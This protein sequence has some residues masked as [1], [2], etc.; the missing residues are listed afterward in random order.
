[1]K[2]INRDA[3]LMAV[4]LICEHPKIGSQ[5]LARTNES[6]FASPATSEVIRRI[7]SHVS[8]KGEVPTYGE[9]LADPTITEDSRAILKAYKKKPSGKMS[10]AKAIVNTLR[11]Y[12]KL[13]TVYYAAEDTIKSLKKSSVDPDKLLD[14]M[15]DRLTSARSNSGVEHELVTFGKNSNMN[16]VVKN[17]LSK[18]KPDVIPTGFAAWDDRNGG[19]YPGSLWVIAATSSGGKS[20]MAGQV[21]KNMAERA[22][23]SVLVP[24]EMTVDETT[25]RLLANISGIDVTKILNKRLTRAERKKVAD[26]YKEFNES[27]KKL[28]TKFSIFEPAEDLTIE[29]ILLGLKPFNYMTHLIDYVGLLKGTDNDDQAR[30][31]SKVARFAKV[32]AKNNNRLVILLAQSTE[33]GLI[34]YSRAINEHANNCFTY[35]TLVDTNRGLVELG[36]MCPDSKGK[37]EIK[38]HVNSLNDKRVSTMQ[39]MNG[40]QKVWKVTT[41]LGYEIEATESQM[42]R[43][44]DGS[45]SKLYE[46]ERGDD[47]AFEY[48]TTW[49]NDY[50]SWVPSN[51]KD[52]SHI[53]SEETGYFLGYL[54]G[55]GLVSSKVIRIRVST[56]YQKNHVKYLFRYLFAHEPVRTQ[57]SA[58]YVF[59]STDESLIRLLQGIGSYRARYMGVSVPKVILQAKRSVAIAY[60]RTL[61]ESQ[62]GSIYEGSNGIRIQYDSSVSKLLQDVQA[63]LL[64]LGIPS[65][66]SRVFSTESSAKR[67]LGTTGKFR[68]VLYNEALCRKYLS[69]VGVSNLDSHPLSGPISELV[70]SVPKSLGYRRQNGFMVDPIR[71][72]RS[73]GRKPTYDITVPETNSFIANGFSVHNCWVWSMTDE[74][75]EAGIMDIRQTKAR[76]HDPFPFQLEVSWSNMRITSPSGNVKQTSKGEKRREKLDTTIDDMSDYIADVGDD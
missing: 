56:E 14:K 31:L 51:G 15:T 66:V 9:I 50:E 49:D 24:L 45:W 43:R 62:A 20:V 10:E 72:I 67:P 41:Q 3:E 61:I 52:L 11:H 53:V 12:F 68:I 19:M 71:S 22:Y 21:L 47:L 74:N 37:S 29:E 35:G 76:N 16:P 1:M 46:L 58:G 27:L 65:L 57:T 48:E 75:R 2:I 42:F 69:I 30:A 60:I 59:T 23:D 7:A 55:C 38:M 54:S 17:I 25:S 40:T 63:I 33:D 73:V 28:D 36:D 13:R 32:W 26:K 5:I 8:I 70:Q 44:P 6:F 34:R 64:K 4:R 39:H 18:G